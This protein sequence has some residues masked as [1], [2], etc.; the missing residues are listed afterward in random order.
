MTDDPKDSPLELHSAIYRAHIQELVKN[1]FATITFSLG[2]L[3]VNWTG[4]ADQM[5]HV[6]ALILEAVDKIH[7]F[8]AENPQDDGPYEAGKNGKNDVAYK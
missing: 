6:S 4:K 3:N 2:D 7:K 8:L 5:H 1:G